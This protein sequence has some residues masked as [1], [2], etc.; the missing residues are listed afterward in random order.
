MDRTMSKKGRILLTGAT[1]YVGG[2]LAPRLLAAGY[3]IR[4]MVRRRPE[5]RFQPWQEAVELVEADPL[6][7]DSLPAALEGVRIAYYLIHSMTGGPAFR[8]RDI[9]AARHFG[10]AARTAGVQRILYLGGLGDDRADLSEHLRSRHETGDALREAGVAVTEFQAAIIVGS[11][12]ISFEMVRYLTERLPVMICPRWVFTKV[13][14][15]AI[16]DV[17]TY[18]VAALENPATADQIIEIGGSD[19]MTYGDMMIRYGQ[20]RGLRRHLIR[21]PVLT[22]RLSSYWIH[23]VTPIQAAYARPLIEGLRNEVIVRD[24]KARTLMPEVQPVDYATAVRRAL[25]E[26]NADHACQA[27]ERHADHPRTPL[28][29]VQ[30]LN[31]EGMIV[32]RRRLTAEAS[33]ATAYR[34]FS[35]LGG[36]KGWL[37]LNWIWRLRGLIDRLV[38]GPGLRRVR[39]SRD[40]LREG[41][42]V[43]CYRVERIEKN[44]LIRL[45]I[46]MRLP[47]EG[48]LQF[49]AT[50]RPPSRSEIVLTVIFA[51]KGLAGLV[52]WYAARP[53]HAIIFTCMLNRLA[54]EAVTS[55]PSDDQQRKTPH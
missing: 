31:R 47:G 9:R 20:V 14:P 8:D 34:A 15:I 40:D 43:D 37:C 3:N 17:L 12:S 45:R 2:Q 5:R 36:R 23:W 38:G 22:P 51:P 46:E 39:P 11:G 24:D 30:R 42:V 21:V 1:G 6:R 32:E 10:E 50:P 33:P 52:Y 4:A 16:D 49:Q 41:D 54:R 18:L 7:P 19:V 27:I 25:H 26:L 44:R 13:Q 55:D 29:S 53:I 28:E 35:S 48:W